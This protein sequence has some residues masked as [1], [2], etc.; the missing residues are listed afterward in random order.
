MKNLDFLANAPLAQPPAPGFAPEEAF[1]K[2]DFGQTFRW[3]TATA[4]FQV[5]G[6]VREDGRGP[7]I[8]DTFTH[9]RGKIKQNH[10]ADLACDFYHRY[11]SDLELLRSLNFNQFRFSIS[12]S[13]VLPA[14]RGAV[15]QAGLDYYHRVIDTCLELGIEPWITLYHWDLPQALQNLGG[16]KNRDVV[17]WFADY[18]ALCTQAFGDKVKNW[19]ILNEPMAVAALGHVTGLHAP[20]Q[21]GLYHFL[22]VVHHL[23]LCQAEGGRVVRQNVPDAYVGTTFSCSQVEPYT[24]RYKDLQAARRADA[25]L[26]RL[27]IE[28]SLGLGY[29]T[30]AFPYLTQIEKYLRPGDDE[31]LAF[32]FDFVGLQ[33]YFRVVV[34]H[35]YLTPGLWAREVPAR[36]RQVPLT[37]MGWEVAPDGLYHI[38]KQFGKYPGV[39][40]IIVSENGAAFA[41]E[42]QNGRVHD[43]QRID[44]FQKYLA[45]VLRAKREGVN[46]GGYLVWSFLDN[47]EW[48]EGYRPRF[49]L[50]YVDYPTQQRIVKDS[51][52]WFADF[53]KE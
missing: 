8:W 44:F 52:Y 37:D 21:R 49:G 9:T 2:A 14:G 46:V 13:R 45:S 20:G 16:W 18:V 38:L 6:A 43:G 11:A 3:G 25:L 5:E 36:E 12:W 35:S 29:P 15:N 17:G 22:P 41:D 51:G 39:R 28:P 48:A 26:N 4:A 32:D 10:H 42:V 40:E 47:F 34:K 7:S 19:I 23:A 27:F 31:R 50:V 53:L 24:L 1:T 30:D 33:N